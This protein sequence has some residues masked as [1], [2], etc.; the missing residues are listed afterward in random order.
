M[1][2]TMN[3]VKVITEETT[4]TSGEPTTFVLLIGHIVRLSLKYLCF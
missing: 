1:S 4:D 3:L 2:C